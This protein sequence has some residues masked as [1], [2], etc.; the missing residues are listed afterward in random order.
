MNRKRSPHPRGKDDSAKIAICV[1][2]GRA[3]CRDGPLRV[4]TSWI[5]ET[6]SKRRFASLSLTLSDPNAGFK[7]SYCTILK[8][9][10]KGVSRK[11]IL[12]LIPKVTS[13]V[14]VNLIRES[15][16]FSSASSEREPPIEMPPPLQ[17]LSPSPYFISCMLFRDL[18]VC[19]C[20]ISI[21]LCVISICRCV[22][23][24]VACRRLRWLLNKR[25]L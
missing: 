12:L 19:L 9:N 15:R 17:L 13:Y 2:G 7:H 25:E 3:C 5:S 23:F 1:K 6:V 22:I 10:A 14:L 20:V 24:V 21:C 11:K 16:S 18:V 8:S 4:G